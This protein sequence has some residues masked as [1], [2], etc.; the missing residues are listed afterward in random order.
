MENCQT[1]LVWEKKSDDGSPHDK[2]TYFPWAGQ[3][4]GAT[5]KYCQPD[6]AAKAQCELVAGTGRFGCDT[7]GSGEGTCNVNP[8]GVNPAPTTTI[9]GW[10]AQLNNTCAD[11]TTDCTSGGNA[12]CARIGNGNCGFAAHRDWRIPK[13]NAAHEGD[14]TGAPAAAELETIIRTGGSCG[15]PPYP[16]CVPPTF[17]TDC[18]NGCLV[19]RCSCT[20]S[21][22][23]WSATT[24]GGN[25]DYAWLV[26]FYDGTVDHYDSGKPFFYHV[27]AVRG[28]S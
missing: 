6:A 1:Q 27:R 12:A 3:C 8:Y 25:P 28:G 22:A 26:S 15:V 7:C 5:S 9:W 19:T 11:G 13:I 14:A 21:S 2:D 20:Q 10:L 18:V 4:M 23:Y 16:P 17:N 24:Y